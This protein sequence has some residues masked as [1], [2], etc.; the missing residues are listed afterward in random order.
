MNLLEEIFKAEQRIRPYILKTPLMK[1]PYFSQLVNSNVY[2]KLESEQ[3]TGSFKLR[4]AIN[5]VLSLSEDEKKKGVITAS[6]GN[7]GQ[8]LAKALKISHAKGI[9]YVPENADISKVEAIKQYGA[10]VKVYGKNA[11]DTEMY[12]KQ[13]A[14]ERQMIWVSPYNDPQIIGGQGT[15]G[16]E[17]TEQLKDIDVIFVTVGGGGLISGIGTYIKSISPQTKIVGCLPENSAEMFESIKSG[18][19]VTSENKDTLSDGSAG[20]FEEGSITYDICKSVIDDFVLV[21]EEEIKQSIRFMV[22]IHHKIIEGAA[23]VALAGFLKEKDTYTGKNV[24]IVIC[25]ANISTDKLL[26][27]LTEIKRN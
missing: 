4:G 5:K 26:R 13:L 19:F 23:G 8:A 14:K 3:Y 9:V 10:E 27:I 20:G 6:T 2:F 17:L 22:D 15:I 25:G 11:L 24:V 16:I 1:S 18:K 7:H 12:A 21:T